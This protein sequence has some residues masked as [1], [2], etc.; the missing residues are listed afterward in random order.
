MDWCDSIIH[1]WQHGI[2]SWLSKPS[3]IQERP[4]WGTCMHSDVLALFRYSRWWV[5]KVHLCLCFSLQDFYKFYEV[6]GLK[7]KVRFHTLSHDYTPWV[8]VKPSWAGTSGAYV[9]CRLD[10]AE[11]TGLMIFLVLHSSSSKVF[12]FVMLIR[13]A[14][15]AEFYSLM[16]CSQW[17]AT[18]KTSWDHIFSSIILPLC[19]YYSFLTGIYLLVKSKAF[20]YTMCKFKSL[21]N[22]LY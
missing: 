2:V 22:F 21:S 18:F 4:C 17:P 11:S 1:E 15:V 13:F 10:G 16:I 6:I 9:C 12:I 7:W 8:F 5:L 14:L 20:Q 19:D 3:T